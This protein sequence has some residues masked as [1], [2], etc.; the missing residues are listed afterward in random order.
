[1]FSLS[2]YATSSDWLN[3]NNNNLR[4]FQV[5]KV[6]PPDIQT[7]HKNC[8][9]RVEVSKVITLEKLGFKPLDSIKVA[10]KTKYK[11]KVFSIFLMWMP[12]TKNAKPPKWNQQKLLEGLNFCIAHP[13]YHPQTYE[14]KQILEKH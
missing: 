7:A 2:A 12:N 10:N 5:F 14:Q 8:N 9:V 4:N 1:M 3:N 6:V 11:E 13:L